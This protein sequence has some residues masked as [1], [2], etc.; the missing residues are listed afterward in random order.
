MGCVFVGLR[1]QTVVVAT[2]NF[3]REFRTI[4]DIVW[5]NYPRS[6]RIVLKS[7]VE[8]A[9]KKTINVTTDDETIFSHKRQKVPK[10]KK[11]HKIGNKFKRNKQFAFQ[12]PR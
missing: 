9:E 8:N 12:I 7:N 2:L 3:V 1:W 5:N 6:M 10:K 11:P 4:L